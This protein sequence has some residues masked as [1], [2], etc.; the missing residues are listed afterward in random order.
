MIEFLHDFLGRM[1]RRKDT[2]EAVN[3]VAKDDDDGLVNLIAIRDRKPCFARLS[4]M[5]AEDGLVRFCEGKYGVELTADGLK[6]ISRASKER[7][8]AAT[9][10]AHLPVDP[11]P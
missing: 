2:K 4:I 10:I 9:K 7:I 11:R 3:W 1:V 6:A 8:L 5:Q